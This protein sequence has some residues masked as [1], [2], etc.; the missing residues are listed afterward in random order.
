MNNGSFHFPLDTYGWIRRREKVSR[1]SNGNVL[2]WIILFIHSRN[3]HHH[4]RVNQKKDQHRFFWIRAAGWHV[5]VPCLPTYVFIVCHCFSLLLLLL[6]FFIIVFYCSG[7]QVIIWKNDNFS[8]LF[9]FRNNDCRLDGNQKKE[10]FFSIAISIQ[11]NRMFNK[12]WS[13]GFSFIQKK[14]FHRDDY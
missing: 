14:K 11:L 8:S 13:L 3:H 4:Q 7:D 12:H 2:C 6:S 5:C 9:L 1:F 10:I